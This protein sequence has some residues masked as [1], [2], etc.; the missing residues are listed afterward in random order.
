M[1]NQVTAK[2]VSALRTK[3]GAGMMDC[4]KALTETGGDVEKAVDLLRK[5]GIAKAEK[6]AGRTASQGII[7]CYQHFTGKVGVLVE[8][9]CE[10]DFVARTDDFQELAKDIALQVASTSPIGVTAEDVPE[11]LLQRERAIVEAQV[12][13]S[14]KPEAVQEKMVDGKIKKFLKERVLLD[15]PFVKDDKRTVEQ[16]V[17]DISAKV[18]ENIVVKRFQRFEL[19]EE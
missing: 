5:K 8:V 6:R 15:Q 14:G 18:G 16:V 11:E 3:T 9:N 12:A 19:G 4:K 17:T 10:T 1:A 7:Y 13:E 2:D